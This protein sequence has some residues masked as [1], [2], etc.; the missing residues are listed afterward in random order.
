MKYPIDIVFVVLVY[1]NYQDLFHLCKSL[2]KNVS[3]PY[4]VVVVDAFY[5][6][7]T[8]RSV[9]EC[10]EKLGCMYIQVENKGYGYGNNCGIQFAHKLFQYQYVVI[11]NPDTELLTF[12]DVRLLESYGDITA[13]QITA[14]NRKRQNPYW[15]YENKTAEWLLYLGYKYKKR[16]C[17]L[18]GTGIH[19]I[20]RYLFIFLHYVTKGRIK[21]IYACHGSFVI[22]S[23]NFIE[24]CHFTY[25]E[26][27]FLF[28]EEA[29]L[30]IKARNKKAKICYTK[31]I[32]VRHKEDGSMKLA[33]L[34]EYPYLRASFL[35]YYETYRKCSRSRIPFRRKM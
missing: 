31:E 21:H 2:K 35:H 23:R 30:A 25:D 3:N 15:A 18:L 5:D 14:M 29:Y 34:K 24:T 9:K 28:Y 16:I 13:P 12:L 26:T 19:K 11:C 32:Q 33:K 8:S 20:L 6:E 22:L 27:M 7:N 17:I 4:K 1:R 10:A